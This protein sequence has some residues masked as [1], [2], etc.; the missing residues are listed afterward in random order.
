[1][2]GKKG[3]KRFLL[4]L[5]GKALFQNVV[6]LGKFFCRAMKSHH[7]KGVLFVRSDDFFSVT[8]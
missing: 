8:Q 1:M 2:R 5:G 7:I 3:K 6:E 4:A